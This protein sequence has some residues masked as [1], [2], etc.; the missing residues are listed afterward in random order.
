MRSYTKFILLT[1][2]MLTVVCCKK[3]IAQLASEKPV[4]SFY[5]KLTKEKLA[6]KQNQRSSKPAMHQQLPGDKILPKQGVQAAD[7]RKKKA[8]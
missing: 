6:E 7:I 2:G 5:S 8:A 1:M 4:A 3:T